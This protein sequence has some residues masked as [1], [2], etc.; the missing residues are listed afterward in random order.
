MPVAWKLTAS[1]EYINSKNHPY[2]TQTGL[3]INVPSFLLVRQMNSS[4]IPLANCLRLE[5]LKNSFQLW[6]CRTAQQMDSDTSAQN[7]Q[8]SNI[9]CT[10]AILSKWWRELGKTAGKKKKRLW[11]LQNTILDFLLHFKF[12]HLIPQLNPSSEGFCMHRWIFFQFSRK[13]WLWFW[14]DLES[15]TTL[16][17]TGGA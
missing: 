11:F 14:I 3:T 4:T 15:Q 10:S 2:E 5:S 8:R 6:G 1:Q 7:H 12:H 9:S 13:M 16:K 17:M